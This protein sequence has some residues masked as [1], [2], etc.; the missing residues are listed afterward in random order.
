MTHRRVV[1]LGLCGAMLIAVVLV[2][3]RRPAESRGA[4]QSTASDVASHRALSVADASLGSSPSEP[5]QALVPINVH[6]P[7][8][9]S[10]VS[11]ADVQTSAL[12]LLSSDD[13]TPEEH[14]EDAQWLR[15]GER[16]VDRWRY[17]GRNHLDLRG[18]DLS[19]A[20][21][22][23][24]DMSNADLRAA[25][26]KGTDL[27]HADLRSANLGGATLEGTF[28]YGADLREAAF[29]D[30]VAGPVN[31]SN[32]DLRGA[33][34]RGSRLSCRD[35]AVWSTAMSANFSRADMRGFD[36][37]SSRVDDSVFD[38]ADLRGAN[39]ANTRGVPRSF[40]EALYDV[41]T[42]FPAGFNPL[43]WKMILDRA[44]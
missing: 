4:D 3:L 38:G 5:D 41:R 21:L 7:V 44:D 30:T 18:E 32:A 39:L 35:C 13:A 28:L 42:R 36:F 43:A 24:V 40:R 20:D 14:I 12:E 15:E 34:L 16:P 11:V 22:E 26:L 2:A 37:G 9:V 17:T 1:L 31:V 6:G 8:P 29:R 27:Q 23:Y 19:G 25:N 10:P 33:D